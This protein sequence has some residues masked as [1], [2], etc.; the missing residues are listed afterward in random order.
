MAKTINLTIPVGT[1]EGQWDLTVEAKATGQANWFAAVQPTSIVVDNSAPVVPANTL[2]QP[3]G[4]EYLHVGDAYN[5]TWDAAKIVEANLAGIDLE[6]WVAGAFHSKIATGL[7]NTGTYA[8]TVPAMVTQQAKVKLV[9][10]D[11][12]GSMGSDMSDKDFTIFNTDDSPPMVNVTAPPDNAYLVNSSVTV[13]AD[14]SDAESGITKVVFEY[15]KD[16]G[17][18]WAAIGTDVAA[19]YTMSWNLAGFADGTKLIV[20][21]TAHNGA[22][23][24]ASDTNGGLVIDRGKPAVTLT[25]PANGAL[26]G[27]SFEVKADAS[28][29]GS[30]IQGV[31]FY[32]SIDSGVTWVA[33]GAADTTA[34]YSAAFSAPW[35]AADSTA[36]WF[37]ASA[38]DNAGWSNESGINKV[39]V[40]NKAPAIKATTLT[41][42]NG[43]EGLQIGTAYTIKWT[44]ADIT[45]T[46]LAASPITLW[47]TQDGGVTFTQIDGALGNTGSFN[48][49]VAGIPSPNSWVKIMATDK[50][51]NQSS[52]MSDAAFTI[53]AVDNTP[54]AASVASPAAGAWITGVK[55]VKANAADAESGIVQVTFF[56]DHGVWAVNPDTVAPYEDNL[57][58]TGYNGALKLWV[59]AKNG[60]G[61]ETTSAVVTVNVDNTAPTVSLTQP[62]GGNLISGTAYEFAAD[63]AD[64]GS[65]V[66]SVLFEVQP[67]CQ[68]GWTALGTATAAPFK[69][70]YN[71]ANLPDGTHCFRATATDKVGLSTMSSVV[72]AD[73]KNTFSIVLK[74]GWNLISTPLVP[75]DTNIAAVMNGLAVK[76]VATFVWSSGK[77]V[78][79]TYIPGAGG[80]LKTFHDGQGY[81][82]EMKSGGTL[83]VKGRY[84]AAPPNVL[85]S[86]AESVGWN[87]IGFTARY[88][89]ANESANEYLGSLAGAA[90][91]NYRWN[92]AGY[93]E[94]TWTY[95]AGFGYWLALSKAGTIYP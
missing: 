25:A 67:N 84:L 85:P 16:N 90:E 69:I 50:V 74:T 5:I 38:V 31:T 76:Q 65:G 6:L 4:G 73:I 88:N 11:K 77:L 55:L 33:L 40:D 36:V 19:P 9:V 59:V 27:A 62:V 45:D 83:V 32:Y 72:T 39:T 30:G 44:K 86:Y 63:A 21:A 70:T 58:T 7:G 64:G 24:F 80:T 18:T 14:A 15:S 26:L 93:Y 57:D 66:A 91:A 53:F 54:P 56:A 82:V 41:Q 79:Q 89:M 52:D 20:K 60:V 87:L 68:G 51:G 10:T 34:P 78:Q 23:A 12:A 29:V 81:W 46:N 49:T 48:W 3:N 22:G 17:A 75:Y 42:P 35:A 61:M 43:G 13:S 37:K 8:W 95:D 92:T 94:Q 1:A 71:T 2:L 47:L 28:D